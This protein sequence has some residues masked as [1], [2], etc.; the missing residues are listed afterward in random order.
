[1]TSITDNLQ[2]AAPASAA[3]EPGAAR[4]A[5]MRRFLEG[6][7]RRMIM[8]LVALGLLI[9]VFSGLS[10]GREVLVSNILNIA[11]SGSLLG[12]VAVGEVVVMIAGGLDI[13]I[14]STAGLVSSVTAVVMV[15]SHESV[16]AGILAGLAVG[17]AAGLVN[18]VMVAYVGV[19]SVIATL[20]TYSAYAGLALLATNGQEIGIA[21]NFFSVLGTGSGLGVPYL[22]WVLLVVCL[23]GG[24]VMRYT[25]VGRQVYAVGGSI[26]AARLAGIKTARYLTMVFVASGL[27]AAVAGVLLA[28]QTGSAQPSEGSVGLELTAITAILLGGVP[29]AGGSGSVLGAI[30]G[31]A[32]LATLDNGLLLV[33]LQEFWQQVATGGLLVTA[34][35]LQ[36]YQLIGDRVRVLRRRLS[37]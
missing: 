8:L 37:G 16:V 12:I 20:A 11:T 27:C 22:V 14:G 2:P 34:V 17:V 21:S 25:D 26:R 6:D 24:F 15:D 33:G 3:P 9:G 4:A 29:L 32:L 19:N 30:L 23:T 28:A 10:S 5:V 36:N 1:M 35:V 18:G 7:G 31:V 13:S